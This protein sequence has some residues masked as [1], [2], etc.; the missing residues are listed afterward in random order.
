MWSEK[1]L[2]RA[3]TLG[4]SCVCVLLQY[5]VVDIGCEY[6]KALAKMD[7]PVAKLHRFIHKKNIVLSFWFSHSHYQ[8]AFIVWIVCNIQC[9]LLWWKCLCMCMC[10]C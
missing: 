10:M 8:V 7:L 4:R 3:A 5:G 1:Q 9:T 6:L 2:L